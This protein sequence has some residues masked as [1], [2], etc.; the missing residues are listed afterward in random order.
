MSVGEHHNKE[1]MVK[2]KIELIMHKCICVYRPTINP[3]VHFMSTHPHLNIRLSNLL[4]INLMKDAYFI[5]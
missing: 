1:E 4:L 5:A 2:D 3:T